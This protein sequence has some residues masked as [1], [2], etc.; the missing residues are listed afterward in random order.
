GGTG[1]QPGSTYT[2]RLGPSSFSFVASVAPDLRARFPDPID[3]GG[4]ALAFKTTSDTAKFLAGLPIGAPQ[5][6]SADPADGETGISP[7]LYSDPDGQF[8]PRR[9]FSLVFDRALRPDLENVSDATFRLVDLDDRPGGYPFGLPL[10]IDVT[11][12]ENEVDRSVVSLSA[13]GILPF[14]H[15]LAL[16]APSDLKSLSDPGAHSGTTTVATT[17]AI[18]AAP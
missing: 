3:A 9:S 6:V 13:S 8:P 16:E 7:N 1:L 18:A 4:I 11:L 5:L 14:G 2:M 15:L 10:G 12:V 17:F